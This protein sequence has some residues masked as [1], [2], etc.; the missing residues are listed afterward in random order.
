M[1]VKGSHEA[2]DNA[3]N[4]EQVEHCVQ[5]LEVMI[6]IMMI[7]VIVMLMLVKPCSKSSCSIGNFCRQAL[8]ARRSRSTLRS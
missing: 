5:K 2:K 6:M 7:M 1:I 3:G 4:G 8:P